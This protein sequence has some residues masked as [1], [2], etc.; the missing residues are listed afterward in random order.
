MDCYC[1]SETQIILDSMKSDLKT[2]L[3]NC[4]SNN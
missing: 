2:L 3:D 1:P 4:K